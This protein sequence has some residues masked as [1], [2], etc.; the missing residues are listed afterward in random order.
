MTIGER[1]TYYRKKKGITVSELARQCG[2]SQSTISEIESGKIKNPSAIV[3]ASIAKNLNIFSDDLLFNT[4]KTNEEK[5]SVFY[6]KYENLSN[7]SKKTIA[8][9]IDALDSD[10]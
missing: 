9:I 3:I 5:N 10:D 7:D 2:C 8:K 1:V 6:R 4:P